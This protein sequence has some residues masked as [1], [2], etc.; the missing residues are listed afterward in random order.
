MDI[1]L[2]IRDMVV[3]DGEVEMDTAVL[4]NWPYIVFL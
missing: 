1:F 3:L 4:E 2:D